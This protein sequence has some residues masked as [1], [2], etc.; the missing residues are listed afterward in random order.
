MKKLFVFLLLIIMMVTL[1][2]IVV[3]AEDDAPTV[4]NVALEAT[5]NDATDETIENNTLFSRLWEF[6][7]KY[8]S[9]IITVIG[10]SILFITAVYV[11]I[12]NKKGANEI[13]N[14][15]KAIKSETGSNASSQ[16][17]V[18]N[19]ANQLIEAYNKMEVEYKKMREAYEKY[20][21]TEIDRNKIIGALAAEIATV[22]EILS[23][24]YVN[25]KHLP[26]GIKD[27]VITKY[28]NCLKA[29]ERD[30]ELCKVVAAVR[31]QLDQKEEQ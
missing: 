27:L 13:N 18:V 22:L 28:A 5:N 7:V 29:L 25:N 31:L 24:V 11:K 10:N 23:T 15:L 9:E 30:E 19:A 2:S 3:F 20:G 16:D 17:N 12:K 14:I 6:F 4:D 1:T 21:E 26:Q 8:R